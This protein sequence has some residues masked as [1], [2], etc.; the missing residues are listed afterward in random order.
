MTPTISAI[1]WFF[2]YSARKNYD[3]YCGMDFRMFPVDTQVR[4]WKSFVVF[5]FY[6]LQTNNQECEV[7]IYSYGSS[8]KDYT[9]R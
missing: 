3:L 5:F 7:Q 1:S 4:L 9:L 8:V 2:R 6:S